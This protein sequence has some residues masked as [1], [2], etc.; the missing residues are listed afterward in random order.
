MVFVKRFR[1]GRE[2]CSGA[3][4]L[5][6]PLRKMQLARNMLLA[7]HGDQNRDVVVVEQEI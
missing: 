2:Q 3:L 7:Q 4:L 1:E 5:M 6:P